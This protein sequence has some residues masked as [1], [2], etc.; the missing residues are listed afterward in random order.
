VKEGNGVYERS[1]KWYARLR[2]GKKKRVSVH[3]PTVTSEEEALARATAVRAVVR[4]LV[5][6]DR[7]DLCERFAKE[8]AV[9]D[10][11]KR[12]GAILK[13]AEAIELGKVPVDRP[14]EG[15]TFADLAKD[16]VDGVLERR[17]PDHVRKRKAKTHGN[18]ASRLKEYINPKIGHLPLLAIT[19]DHCVVVMSDLPSELSSATRRHVA[20]VVHR[21]MS[22]AAYPCRIIKQSPIPRGWLPIITGQK[23]FGYLYPDEDALLL[24][25]RGIALPYRILYG[26]LAREG[27]RVSEALTADLTSV[28]RARGVFRLDKNK[29]NDPRMWALD[30]AV[31]RAMRVW[32]AHPARGKTHHLFGLDEGGDPLL[33]DTHLVELFRGHLAQAGVDRAELFEQTPVRSPIR[34]HDL[35]ATFITVALAQGKSETWISDRTGHRTSG[36]IQK[37]R[38]KARTVSE[39]DLGP[40]RPLDEAIPE[41]AEAAHQDGQ[42][43]ASG[44]V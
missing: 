1:G 13:A 27:C 29:T 32:L 11:P 42:Q 5:S 22:L 44:R 37:Y 40:L 16:L 25:C 23:I 3:L 38:R 41:L 10:S 15:I 39:L 9:S 33:A 35:R 18:D 34:I 24:S 8:V 26:F 19:Q 21:V 20:Q 43:M 28:D 7:P 30:P 6:Y 36:M 2:L 12:L 4:K 17:H 31:A 14:V